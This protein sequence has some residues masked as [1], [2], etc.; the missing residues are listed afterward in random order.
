MTKRPAKKENALGVLGV[1]GAALA[2]LAAGAAAMFLTK[3]EN[4]VMVKKT[5]DA[6]VKKGKKEVVK[7]VAIAK[8]KFK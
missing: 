1:I 2:G 4:R 6:T 7:Q 8:K 3:E 5:V